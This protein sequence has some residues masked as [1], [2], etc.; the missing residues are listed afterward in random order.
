MEEP[1]FALLSALEDIDT[2]GKY[3]I[4]SKVKDS[5]T[6]ADSGIQNELYWVQQKAKEQQLTLIDV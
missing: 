5:T 2:V 1:P 6:A 4:N 3:L